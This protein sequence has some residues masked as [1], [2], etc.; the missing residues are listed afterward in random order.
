MSALAVVV[1]VDTVTTTLRQVETVVIVHFTA[2]HQLVAAAVLL[3][4]IGTEHI[5]LPLREAVA[6][7]VVQGLR[8]LQHKHIQAVA[9]QVV[10][11]ITVALVL[12]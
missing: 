9:V 6:L 8:L 5:L 10:K 12:D 11:A 7:A 2:I 1:Q 3:T 4:K